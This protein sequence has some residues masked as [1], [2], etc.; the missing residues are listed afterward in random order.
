VP[1]VSVI[2]PTYN[3]KQELNG[4]LSSLQQQTLPASD[5][6]IIVVDDGSSDGT[7]AYLKTL[8]ADG[9]EN[10]F[11]CYQKNQGPG[12]ARNCG[13]AMARG[14]LFAFTDTDC[15]PLPDWLEEL[16]KPFLDK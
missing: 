5:F 4:L 10:L 9:R 2:I 8:V 14:A 11:F 15:R 13:M 3:R 7:L 1:V 6:E 16:I 12:A